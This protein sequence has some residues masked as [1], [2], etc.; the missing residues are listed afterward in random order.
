MSYIVNG[1]ILTP[2]LIKRERVYS[3]NSGK[4]LTQQHFKTECDINVIVKR[5]LKTGVLP[6]MRSSGI[7]GDFSDAP[8][9]QAAMDIVAVAQRQFD[10]L[11][12]KTR[13]RFGNDPKQ[14]LEFVADPANSDDMIKMGLA[15]KPLPEVPPEPQKVIIVNPEAP[16]A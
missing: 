16:T 13:Q 12:A 6:E 4:S 5:F 3:K 1:E 14:F 8:S 11:D 10:G 7:Y 15:T 9:F 2:G